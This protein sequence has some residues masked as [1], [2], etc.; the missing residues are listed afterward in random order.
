MESLPGI[1]EVVGGAGAEF[2]IEVPHGATREEHFDAARGRLAGEYA[3]ELKEFFFVNTDVGAPEVAA[4]IAR[5]LAEA[6]HAVCTL[7]GLLPRTFIDCNRDIDAGLRGDEMTPPVPSSGERCWSTVPHHSRIA[8]SKSPERS[9]L[10]SAG[11][12]V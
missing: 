6:G 12:P 8:R 2:L 9:R 4:E 1:C 5:Q 3:A 11:S 7:R 10:R